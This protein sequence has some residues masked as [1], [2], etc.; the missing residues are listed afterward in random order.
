M[1]GT[2][3]TRAARRASDYACF[4]LYV[5]VGVN[6]CAIGNYWID[7]NYNPSMCIYSLT[8]PPCYTP[9]CKLDYNTTSEMCVAVQADTGMYGR[10]N[11]TGQCLDLNQQYAS[12]IE[13]CYD[14]TC[15]LNSGGNYS[16]Q[17]ITNVTG[18]YG[19]ENGT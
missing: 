6:Q 12:A 9:N 19:K 3:L 18:L 15:I 13:Y 5:Q 8:P 17:L 10:A 14:T 1:N 16:C 4:G 7:M 2:S 11:D